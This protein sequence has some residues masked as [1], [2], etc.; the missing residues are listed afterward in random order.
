MYPSCKTHDFFS[1]LPLRYVG[2][3]LRNV[4]RKLDAKDIG[5]SWRGRVIAF[6]L[7]YV[8]AIEAK[9]LDLIV[10]SQVMPVVSE[11]LGENI[12]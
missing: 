8:H 4:P 7:G 5:P 10:E 9:S 3:K 2:T 6:P 12:P 11:M 1:R